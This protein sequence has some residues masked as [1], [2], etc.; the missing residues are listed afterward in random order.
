MP[1]DGDP[2]YK[3]SCDRRLPDISECHIR[4]TDSTPHLLPSKSRTCARDCNYTPKEE[5]IKGLSLRKVLHRMSWFL[6]AAM[7]GEKKG[8]SVNPVT[9]STSDIR[10]PRLQIQL[11]YPINEQNALGYNTREQTNVV[12][13]S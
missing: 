9:T 7:Y 12:T 8:S 4:S 6:A 5:A 13:S 11:L 3:V 1:L 2:I 10:E